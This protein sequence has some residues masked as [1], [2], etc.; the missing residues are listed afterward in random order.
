M[1]STQMAPARSAPA[2]RSRPPSPWRAA[3]EAP[4][5]RAQPAPP[6]QQPEPPPASR[7]L[8]RCHLRVAPH[9]PA[10]PHPAD[11]A[12]PVA[13]GATAAASASGPSRVP[14]GTDA[15]SKAIAAVTDA[16]LKGV[17]IHLSRF[18]GDC[19]ATVGSNT[20]LTK[21]VGECPTITTLTNLFNATNKW[22]IKVDRLGGAAWDS[23]Y[24]TLN[25]AIAGGNP[26]DV[27]IMHG[28]SLVDYAKRGPAVADGRF[29]RDHRHQPGGRRPRCEDRHRLQRG[30]NYAV[31][32]DVHAALAQVNVDLFKAAGLVNPD[33]TAKLPTLYRRVPRRRRRGQEG[34]R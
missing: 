32:F 3:A 21:A 30:K 19:S 5:H 31:P 13:G 6:L 18:F 25:A 28:S 14:V 2:S 9:R 12:Q 23:Y 34:H 11:P 1:T 20:D 8:R 29:G 27:A 17:T 22:G 16:Q 33:G 10:V 26:P 4:A 7:H 15:T 24:D